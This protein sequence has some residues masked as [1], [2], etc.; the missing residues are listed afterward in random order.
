M[1]GVSPHMIALGT[2]ASTRSLKQILEHHWAG[3]PR[4]CADYLMIN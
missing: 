4:L 3:E 2:I 1:E